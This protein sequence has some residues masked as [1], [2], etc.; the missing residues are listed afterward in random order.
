MAA[1]AKEFELTVTTPDGTAFKDK[2]IQVSVRGVEGDLAVLAGHIPFVTSIVPAECR[3]YLTNGDILRFSS[4]SG[5]LSVTHECV[6]L[7]TSSAVFS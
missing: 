3:I 7:L 1:D 5:L 4:G 6:T 2:V